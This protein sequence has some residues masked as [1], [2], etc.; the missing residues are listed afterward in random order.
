MI[1]IRD[2]E[3]EVPE[4]LVEHPAK[5]LV[6]AFQDASIEAQEHY[7]DSFKLAP[8]PDDIRRII[9]FAKEIDGPTLIHC[10]AG[11]SRSPAVALVVISSKT[12]PGTGDTRAIEELQKV[13]HCTPN[14]LIVGLADFVMGRGGTLFKAAQRAFPKL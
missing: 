4:G 6:M 12:G 3:S 5:K 10:E 9:E 11:M 8:T 13:T 2:P 14:N 1:S 7:P